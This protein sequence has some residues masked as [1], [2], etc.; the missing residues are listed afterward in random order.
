MRSIVVADEN[1]AAIPV[2]VTIPVIGESPMKWSLW[3]VAG[4]FAALGSLVW[5]RRPELA[6]AAGL[7][8]MAATASVA[9]A[10]APAAGGPQLEWA[11]AIQYAALAILGFTFFDFVFHMAG[12]HAPHRKAT[13]YLRRVLGTLTIVILLGYPVTIF[14]S[15]DVYEF[16]LPLLAT[17]LASA[18]LSSVYVLLAA[19]IKAPGGSEEDR[20]R[21]PLLGMLLGATPFP[22]ATLV[23]LALGNDPLAPHLTVLPVILIPSAFAYSILHDQLWGIRRLIHRSLVYGL[24][25]AMVLTIVVGGIALSQRLLDNSQNSSGDIIAV[26]L[27]A[28]IGISVYSPLRRGT[29]WVIDRAMYGM[30]PSYPEF[31]Q[32]LQRDLASADP[33]SELPETLSQVLARHLDLESTILFTHDEEGETEV[34]SAVGTGTERVL[35]ALR[36]RRITIP[37]DDNDDRP[38]LIPFE[39]EQILSMQL[40]A[41]E[42]HVA[43]LFLGPKNGGE[44]FIQEEVNLV[45]NAAPFMAAALERHEMSET[46]RQLNRRLVE[47]DEYSRQRMAVDLHDG[48][49]QKAVA[50]AIGRVVDPEGQREMATELVNELRELG[51]RLRP[52]ILDDLGLPS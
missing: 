9:L 45:M 37:I 51:S 43:T 18:L 2:Q 20:L 19:V 8:R 12:E 26:S 41:A 52:S 28:F 29:R 10:I 31:V 1:G 17:T 27:V 7:G 38:N 39:G 32:G 40:W 15:S 46:M 33:E 36:E 5:Y 34:L 14:V 3:A 50:L 11:L 6:S 25:S 35:E 22:L 44:L 48:P 24:V 42:Q 16:V 21:V 30:T 23:P 49:L 4:F 47:T 13:I